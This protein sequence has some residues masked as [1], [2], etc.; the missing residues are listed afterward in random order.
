MNKFAS[1]ITFGLVLT[2]ASP[3]LWG[4]E[5]MWLFNQVPKAAI[6]KKYGFRVTDQFA[7]QLQLGSVRF[8]NGGSGS[9]VSGEGLLF[10]NHHVGMDCIQKVSSGTN[11]YV[12]NGFQA[13][14]QIGRAHV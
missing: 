3:L 14:T 4:D 2:L 7:R 9:F 11:D 8:N 5:G 1:V 6:A 13:R 10:T 12:K